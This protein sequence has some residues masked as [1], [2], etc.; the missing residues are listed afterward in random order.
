MIILIFIL[1]LTIG[2]LAF[3]YSTKVQPSILICFEPIYYNVM[4]AVELKMKL[5]E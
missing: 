4:E 5:C 2:I 3:V 1:E